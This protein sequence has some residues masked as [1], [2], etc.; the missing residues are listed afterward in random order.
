MKIK[1]QN[2]NP[3]N[4]ALTK[5]KE[6]NTEYSNGDFYTIINDKGKEARY[7]IDL[8]KKVIKETESLEE[9]FKTLKINSAGNMATFT[10]NDKSVSIKCSNL[11]ISSTTI[12]CGIYQVQGVNNLYSVIKSGVNKILSYNNKTKKWIKEL[13]EIIFRRSLASQ[14][15]S[16]GQMCLFYI[17]STNRS[18]K[19][20]SEILSNMQGLA[21]TANG[22]NPNSKNNISLWSFEKKFLIKEVKSN[23]T[24]PDKIV[25]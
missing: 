1:I 22:I 9:I 18:V 15:K 8:F 14:I 17:I 23:S 19:G 2:I 13:S 12:S 16:R 6:Y 21:A 7:H 24:V 25:V 5:D 11:N 20:L 10:F 4:Y 3:K